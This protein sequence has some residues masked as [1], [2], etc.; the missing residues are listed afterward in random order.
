[1]HP[2]D[3]TFRQLGQHLLVNRQNLFQQRQTVERLALHL[4]Q[5]QIGHR[6]QQHRLDAMA[7]RQRFVHF[8]QQLSP[9]QLELLALLEFGHHVVIVGVEPFGHFRRGCR[10]AGRCAATADAK[11][12]VQIDRTIRILMAR[13][14]VA[15]QQAGGQHMIVP[16]E[17]ADRHQIHPGLPL[18][19]PMTSTQ[20]AANR[21]Q[22]FLR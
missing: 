17:I 21:Q 1:M 15:Q 10:L 8:V 14:H 3:A 6:A 7:E 12:R 13:R 19:L 11:Q 9:A 16:G 4:T 22:L 18:L 20:L 5:P 2:L